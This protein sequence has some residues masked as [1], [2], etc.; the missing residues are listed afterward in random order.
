MSFTVE[1]DDRTAAVVQELATSEN[2]TASEVVRS[3]KRGHHWFSL[4]R[5]R[6]RVSRQSMNST[7]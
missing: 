6:A 3:V 2:R 4:F 5:G 7:P 1:L